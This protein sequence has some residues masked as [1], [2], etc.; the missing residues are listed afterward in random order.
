M[1]DEPREPRTPGTP[2]RP[3]RPKAW[4]RLEAEFPEVGR[5]YEA[6]ADATRAA[7][8]LDARSAALV[9]VAVS[10]GRGSWRTV[11][12]HAKK[13]LAEGVEPAALRQVAL[14]ALP[15]VGLPAALDALRWIDESVD[16]T[17]VLDR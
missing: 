10:V 17:G 1:T 11:H 14:I 3:K 6:L 13:A 4:S 12:A 9:K 5:A 16:E 8:P 15:T 2:G 7:G